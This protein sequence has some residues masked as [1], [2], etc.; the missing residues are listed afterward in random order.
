M[1]DDTELYGLDQFPGAP[2]LRTKSKTVLCLSMPPAAYQSRSQTLKSSQFA[3]ILAYG[4][5]SPQI[6]ISLKLPDR[7]IGWFLLVELFLSLT[8][9]LVPLQP[10]LALDL[11]SSN[12]SLSDRSQLVHEFV[13]VLLFVDHSCEPLLDS[14]SEI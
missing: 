2:S 1:D 14:N 7:N 12:V 3:I 9:G 8:N 10:V 5:P 13:I 11:L 6:F 4:L